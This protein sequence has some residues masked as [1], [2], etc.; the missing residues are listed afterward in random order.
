MMLLVAASVGGILFTA[1][2]ATL[3]KSLSM[4]MFVGM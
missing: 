2:A 3:E 1:A 4:I